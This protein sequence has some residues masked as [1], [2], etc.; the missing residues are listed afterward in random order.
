MASASQSGDP[1]AL[2]AFRELAAVLADP[3]LSASVDGFE[4]QIR[5]RAR[6]DALVTGATSPSAAAEIRLSTIAFIELVTLGLPEPALRCARERSARYLSYASG[7]T[8][9][10]AAHGGPLVATL[11]QGVVAGGG[12][13]GERC[14]LTHGC[15]ASVTA[16]LLRAA[17]SAHF[18]LI[19]AEGSAA[20]GGHATAAALLEAGVPVRMIEPCAVARVMAS[21]AL[22]LCGAH[23]VLQD[24]GVVGDIGTLTIAHCAAAHNRPFCVAA[25]H[26]LLTR[27]PPDAALLL[28]GGD[29]HEGGGGAPPAGERNDATLAAIRRRRRDETPPRLIKLILTDAGVMPPAAV[30]DELLQRERLAGAPRA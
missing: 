18:T 28:E 9:R 11:L 20:G 7:G 25:P 29:G 3:S 5:L 12:S 24:G 10:I 30:A 2:V 19:V 8:E 16:I 15:S 14:V 27:E 23:A 22:V 17:Q 6:A 13:G 26:Y 1:P 4:L 21:V